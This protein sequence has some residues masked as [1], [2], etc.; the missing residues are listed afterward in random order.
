M[1]NRSLKSTVF[2]SI[3]CLGLLSGA[4]LAEGDLPSPPSSVKVDAMAPAVATVTPEAGPAGS[5][6]TLM[7][8][9]L[10]AV[11]GVVFN[12][13]RHAT[14]KVVDD[15]TIIAVV[16]DGAGTGP[17]ELETPVGVVHSGMVFNVAAD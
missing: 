5:E 10:S 14:F 15:T 2:L 9:N 8:S 6:V 11:T 17:I 16:P 4:A 13:A 12:S 7:G 1:T 3:A